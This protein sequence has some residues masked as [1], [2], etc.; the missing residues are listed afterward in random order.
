MADQKKNTLNRLAPKTY[1]Q[2]LN[3]MKSFSLGFY[4]NSFFRFDKKFCYTL[5][6]ILFLTLHLKHKAS[7]LFEKEKISF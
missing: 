3:K 5:A 7:F 1:T 4:F 6:S 2:K